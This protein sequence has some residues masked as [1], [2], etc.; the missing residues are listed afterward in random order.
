MA[1]ETLAF[2]MGDHEAW[3]CEY[4]GHEILI[5]N[6]GRTR[7]VID[8]EEVAVQKGRIPLATKLNL[9]GSIKET[10]ELVIVTL[11]GSLSNEYRGC[12]TE[13]HVYIGSEFATQYGY[14]DSNKNFTKFEGNTP[15]EFSLEGLNKK[16][17]KHKK[18]RKISIRRKKKKTNLE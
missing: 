3:R 8:G 5:V 10:G 7:L 1:T 16:N 15:L 9:I 17:K 18:P 6:K 4:N 14:V 13:V 2:K 12:R 11:N